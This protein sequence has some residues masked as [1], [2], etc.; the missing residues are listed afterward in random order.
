MPILGEAAQYRA[1]APQQPR[2]DYFARLCYN[3][4]SEIGFGACEQIFGAR[5]DKRIR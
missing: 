2:L 5:L 3:F 4:K 1:A